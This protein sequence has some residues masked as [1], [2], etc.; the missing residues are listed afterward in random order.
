VP[1][2]MHRDGGRDSGVRLPEGEARCSASARLITALAERSSVRARSTSAALSSTGRTA[3]TFITVPPIGCRIG[4]RQIANT[5][6]IVIVLV[7]T[8]WFDALRRRVWELPAPSEEWMTKLVE[9]PLESGGSMIVEVDDR[10]APGDVRRGLGGRD[11]PAEIAARAGETLEAAFGRIQPAAGAM[12]SRLRGLADAPEE[13]EIEFGIQLS[14]ELGVIVA[15]T[16]GE[17]NFRVTLRWKRDN[18]P[19]VS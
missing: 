8:L 16:A 14:A 17:A 9:F 18:L 3:E 4:E 5:R 2:P 12:V 7:R 19:R 13:I 1:A 6:H 10:R 15:H 11:H